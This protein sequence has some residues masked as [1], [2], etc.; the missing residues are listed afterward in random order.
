MYKEFWLISRL[1][2]YMIL[3]LE[4]TGDWYQQKCRF[5]LDEY[6]EQVELRKNWF[7]EQ[8]DTYFERRWLRKQ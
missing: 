6:S 2:K 1:S 3:H 5:Y 7:E 8:R 4:N